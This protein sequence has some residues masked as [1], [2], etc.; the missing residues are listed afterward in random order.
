MSVELKSG[1]SADLATIDATS[2]ALRSTFYTS[3]GTEIVKDPSQGIYHLPVILRMSAAVAV[4]SLVWSMRNGSSKT[5]YIDEIQLLTGF[6]GTVAASVSRFGLVRFSG[7]NPTGG[8]AMTP[9]KHASAMAAST[10]QDAQYDG[11][12]ALT[13]TGITF[14]SYW[15]IAGSQRQVN[16]TNNLT[17]RAD[18]FSRRGVFE[19]ASNE[20]LGIRL[21]VAAVIGDHCIGHVKWRED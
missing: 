11:T 15:A 6:D 16:S 12:A 10:V 8:T 9:V 14:E 1:A 3:G 13:V 4:D 18:S 17:I 2:K 5:I 19:L 20:G 21:Q 7:A